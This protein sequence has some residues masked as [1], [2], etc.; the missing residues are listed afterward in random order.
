M[1]NHLVK[2]NSINHDSNFH[3][4]FSS[5]KLINENRVG[6]DEREHLGHALIRDIFKGNFS[7]PIQD[8]LFDSDT[9]ILDVGCG[10]GFW[11]MEMASDYQKPNYFGIDILPIFPEFTCPKR[12][13]FRQGN[14]F[15]SR[16][17]DNTFDFI[18]MQFLVCDFTVDQWENFVFQELARI[19]KP[20]GWLEICDPEFKFEN[21]GPASNKLNSAVCKNIRSKNGDPLIVHRHRSLIE[22]IPSFS[23]STLHHEKRK[24]PLCSLDNKELGELGGFH[25]KES[26]RNILQGPVGKDLNIK[27]KEIDSYLDKMSREFILSR[28]YFHVHRFYVQKSWEV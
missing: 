11:L 23:S 22:S 3:K 5:Y 16:Y 20:G 6:F 13:K 15:K 28:S 25:T 14:F 4:L 27:P 26:C 8:I 18:H 2:K 24:F 7:S 12:I 9:N 10:S 21:D 17:E 19:L 1:G